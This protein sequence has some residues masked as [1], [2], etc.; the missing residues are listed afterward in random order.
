MRYLSILTMV[1]VTLI[2]SK[3][4]CGFDAPSWW[5]VNLTYISYKL[6]IHKF[7]RNPRAYLLKTSPFTNGEIKAQRG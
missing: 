5:R 1:P 2:P 3:A 4:N 7:E 6:N